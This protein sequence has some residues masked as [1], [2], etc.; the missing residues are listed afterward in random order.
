MPLRSK[1]SSNA[2]LIILNSLEFRKNNFVA[3][4]ICP[5]EL[6]KLRNGNMPITDNYVPIGHVGLLIAP[7]K[8]NYNFNEPII[9]YLDHSLLHLVT[10]MKKY[11]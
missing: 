11:S 1:Q 7:A 5:G 6:C 2:T 3:I 8:R 10:E 9:S 4:R